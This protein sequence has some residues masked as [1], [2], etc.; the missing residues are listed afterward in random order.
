MSYPHDPKPPINW[1]LIL[2][3]VLCLL[4]WAWVGFWIDRAL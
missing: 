3:V 4:V 1:G 2:A